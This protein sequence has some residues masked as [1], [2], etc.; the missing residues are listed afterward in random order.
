MLDKLHSGINYSVVDSKFNGNELTILNNTSLKTKQPSTHTQMETHIEQ[1]PI[2]TS[3]CKCD[4]KMQE[5]NPVFPLGEM[6]HY[7]PIQC[8]P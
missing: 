7:W 6:I 4:Q 2:L 5:P 1:G 3:H 8:W